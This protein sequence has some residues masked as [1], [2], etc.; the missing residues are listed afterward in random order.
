MFG[1][2]ARRRGVGDFDPSGVLPFL[3]CSL[4]SDG[5]IGSSWT[6]TAAT[7]D[8]TPAGE[9]SSLLCSLFAAA[10]AAARPDSQSDVPFLSRL[11]P[12]LAIQHWLLLS[13]SL[14]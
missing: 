1:D 12:L 13:L 2:C 11:L 4:N 8:P 9:L 3:Y 6:N 14:S 5:R 7:R 10:A